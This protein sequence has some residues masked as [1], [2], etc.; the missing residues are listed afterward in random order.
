MTCNMHSRVA[1][2]ALLEGLVE[3]AG[4]DVVAL[5]EWNTQ[6]RSELLAGPDWHT[7][8]TPRLFL[9]SRFPI[10]RVE[11]LGGN[12]YG[13]FGSVAR[14]E[15]ETPAGVLTLFSLHL[16]SPRDAIAEAVH[17][18]Q[19]GPADVEGNTALRRRQSRFVAGVAGLA[20]GPVLLVGDFNTPVESAIFREAWRG[21]ADAFESAGWGWGYTFYGSRTAV[22][23]DHV[24]AGPGWRCRRCWVGPWVGSPHRPVVADLVW[25]GE[26]G[27]DP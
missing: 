12:S 13:G 26:P 3:R 24:L 25:E 5:Q 14:Y 15:L 7:H 9:A 1:D 21:Y 22:R 4:P 8:R 23:I 10:R 18:E 19:R 17:E 27:G 16:A 2:P 20:R 6:N 11:T